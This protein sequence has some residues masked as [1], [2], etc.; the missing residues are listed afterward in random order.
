MGVGSGGRL[1]FL[2][3]LVASPS[4]RRPLPHSASGESLH[5]DLLPTRLSTPHPVFLFCIL[6]R[7]EIP[8]PAFISS[9]A[10]LGAPR[11]VTHSRPH[12]LRAVTLPRVIKA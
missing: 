5:S 9:L 12:R 8:Q 2:S 3:P 11:T 1:W 7:V 10:T 4:I 6:H